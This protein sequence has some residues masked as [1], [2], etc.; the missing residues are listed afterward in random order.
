[1]ARIFLSHSSSNNPEA[2]ALGDWLVAEGWDD[3]FLDLDPARGITAGERWERSLHEA[4]DRCD[5][6]LFLVSREWLAS[7]WCRRE[8]RLAQKLNK[9]TFVVLIED[10]PLDTLPDELTGTWQ[11]VRLGTGQDH[12]LFRVILPDSGQERHV[13]FSRA[14][15]TQLRAGLHKAELDPRFFPWPPEHDPERPPYRGM[16]PL[17]AEDAGIF[18]GRDGPIIDLLARLRG[19]RDGPAPRLLVIL[20]A[21]GSGKSSFL[22]AGI[23][24][25]LQRDDRHFLALPV[26]RPG[27]AVIEETN[28][29][30]ISVLERT[31][32]QRRIP[33]NRAAIRE[34]LQGE[35]TALLTW[36]GELADRATIPDPLT[37]GPDRPPA[38]VL[39]VDQG[40][41]LFQADGAAEANRFLEL[42]GQLVRAEKPNLMVI[43]TIRSD[44]YDSL[45][46]AKPL[47]GIS[48]QTFSLP[49]IPRGAYQSIIEGPARRFSDADRKLR[50]EPQLTET[51]LHEI[52]RGGGKDALPLLAFTLEHLYTQYGGDGD[53]KL[54]EYQHMGGLGGVIDKAVAQALL[55]AD[56]DPTIPRD[57]SARES[58]L[59]RGLI[60]WLAGIDPITQAPRRRVANLEEIP[61]ESRSL[62]RLLIEARLL[63]TDKDPESGQITV[64]PAHEALLRQWGLLQGWL[65]EDFAALTLLD[66]IQR[67]S[68]DWLANDRDPDWL[69]HSAG[70]LEDAEHLLTRNDLSAF[71]TQ[72]N[73]EYLAACRDQEDRRRNKEKSEAE[74][75]ERI[76]KR[77][78]LA[79]LLL[80]IIAGVGGWVGFSGQRLAE[81][82]NR[83]ATASLVDSL[84]ERGNR[85]TEHDNFAGGLD[86]FA[87]AVELAQPGTASRRLAENLIQ[88]WRR[89]TPRPVTIDLPGKEPLVP[90]D[91][92]TSEQLNILYQPG[93]HAVIDRELHPRQNRVT[94]PLKGE[95]FL[96]DQSQQLL[97]ELSDDLRTLEIRK[98][99][100]SENKLIRIIPGQ[101]IMQWSLSPD[102]NLL[103]LTGNDE[104]TAW[105]YDP[106]SGDLLFKAS[107]PDK[108][109]VIHAAREG[110]LLGFGNGEL[111][112]LDSKPP[113]TEPSLDKS[114]E[115]DK[116]SSPVATKGSPDGSKVNSGKKAAPL[117]QARK[118]TIQRFNRI[119]THICS[120]PGGTWA[121]VGAEKE[122]S[123]VDLATGRIQPLPLASTLSTCR[124]LDRENR[125]LVADSTGNAFLYRA[126]EPIELVNGHRFP[127]RVNTF[128]PD[129]RGGMVATL[130]GDG[131]F[132][133]SGLPSWEPLTMDLAE[134]EP[135]LHAGFLGSTLY[136]LVQEKGYRFW[137]LPIIGIDHVPS[138]P[139]AQYLPTG[140]LLL[141][142]AENEGLTRFSGHPGDGER[143]L[144]TPLPRPV[145]MAATPD[146]S[147]VAV[148]GSTPAVFLFGLE[149][150]RVRQLTTEVGFISA[151]AISPRGEWLAVGGSEGDYEL[152]S[153]APEKR[154]RSRKY[155]GERILDLRFSPTGEHLALALSEG[156]LEVWPVTGSEPIVST[157]HLGK[158]DC[159]AEDDNVDYRPVL[160]RFSADG[161]QLA[162]TGMDG[163]IK[164][165]HLADGKVRQQRQLPG[166]IYEL[167]WWGN[168][169]YAGE[170]T[171][172]LLRL[173]STLEPDER[174]KA[175]LQTAPLTTTP[176][177]ERNAL[178]VSGADGRL[179]FLDAERGFRLGLPIQFATPA[180]SIG[181]DP[182]L[183][184]CWVHTPSQGLFRI[185]P[186]VQGSADSSSEHNPS[187]EHFAFPSAASPPT[188]D[189]SGQWHGRGKDP[190][191]AG[192]AFELKLEHRSDQTL[193]GHFTWTRTASEL[194]RELGPAG[195]EEVEGRYDPETRLVRLSSLGVASLTGLGG[196][197]WYKA[198]VPDDGLTIANGIWGARGTLWGLWSAEK[199][200]A[201]K[202]GK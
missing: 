70:R 11:V 50:I 20:G 153:L 143:H 77:V 2:L 177:P 120:N 114:A 105:A 19:L 134:R 112:L 82:K 71:L 170:A 26:I 21:S 47:E 152:W 69:D 40:E 95:Y 118:K 15:L 41:E 166:Q 126:G 88:G 62:I 14:G 115:T 93:I 48:Q 192:W 151:L 27:Q 111:V 124:F 174:F 169:I 55:P 63:A 24:P 131:S 106:G 65:Q 163:R 144:R 201:P 141:L 156:T 86:F 158:N 6:V 51:L 18:F 133:I 90:V 94:P 187:H 167:A 139:L 59:R 107:F 159:L 165:W 185:K 33:I 81:E 44:S 200:P 75:R 147:H 97:I 25:R 176:L 23:L 164:L 137:H 179:W 183:A 172:K 127:N 28:H 122:A 194:G 66:G 9:R 73:R 157:R 128:F 34:N 161:R 79:M 129:P 138:Q 184:F 99:K 190:N 145:R 67:G 54:E 53:L 10:L 35:T 72:A 173:T 125:F 16:R 108:F 85:E 64:E 17:E 74:R 37:K 130:L 196:S 92:T 91:A 168:E 155:A 61:P 148:S 116:P 140:N 117:L 186:L 60:P 7:E 36:L 104:K 32:R 188:I 22:R 121:V 113:A 180:S 162:S 29:G 1:M 30:L 160:G 52:E 198:T 39:S 103:G 154:V 68:R 136:A 43:F 42:I 150:N 132:S 199:E 58:L 87:K 178:A 175:H 135:I 197:V 100:F 102:G 46:S 142:A 123:L 89:S 119:I 96:F 149:E 181:C 83:E 38:L 45:Q 110:L 78:A 109:S 189:L 3:F 5:A 4:A 12:R 8:F 76:A 171:G 56:R 146:A 57:R 182:G 191:V 13:L 49:P 80:A 98:G 193:K 195:T 202:T 31:F 101:P 84:I